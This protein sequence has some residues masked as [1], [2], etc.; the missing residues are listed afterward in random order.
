MPGF[1]EEAMERARQLSHNR[2]P[3]PHYE[4]PKEPP[5]PPV[6]A[7]EPPKPAPLPAT[8]PAPNLIETLLK[9]K[10]ASLIVMLLTLLM[11]EQTDPSLLFALMYLLL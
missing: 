4:P 9:D 7:P 8:K 10:E 3:Q 6:P 1:E 5:K 11:D 2:R